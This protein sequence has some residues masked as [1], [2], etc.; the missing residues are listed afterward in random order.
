MKLYEL[1]IALHPSLS[2]EDMNKL[3]ASIEDLFPHGVKEKDDI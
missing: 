2:T 1:I 3:I